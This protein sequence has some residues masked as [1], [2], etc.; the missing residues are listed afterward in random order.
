MGKASNNPLGLEDKLYT[1][2]EFALALRNKF[3]A[4]D[5]LPD[6]LLVN[7]FV[8]KYPM[9]ACKIKKSQEQGAQNSCS[10]C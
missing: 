5:N 8:T 4:N 7:I 1:T 6:S 9:Y 10:C 2:E 3:G